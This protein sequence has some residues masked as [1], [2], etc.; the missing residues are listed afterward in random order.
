MSDDR[1][2][3]AELQRR[4]RPSDIA[5]AVP[6]LLEIAAAAVAWSGTLCETQ[7]DETD[8]HQVA[9]A[10]GE[11]AGDTHAEA[12][13]VNQAARALAEALAKVRP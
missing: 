2:S 3:I 12:C 5:D 11:C 4:M 6:A 7:S 13:P 10:R 9:E 8:D 1:P